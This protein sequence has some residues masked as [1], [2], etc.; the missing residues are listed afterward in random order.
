MYFSTADVPRDA[1]RDQ[2]EVLDAYKKERQKDTL[3]FEF[4]DSQNLREHL[5]NHLPKI[6]EEVR[7]QLEVSN[8]ERK[9]KSEEGTIK[10]SDWD[11]MTER[12]SQSCRSLRA[13]SQWTS[14]TRREV[15]RIAGGNGGMCEA[16]L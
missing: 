5:I 2:L 8:F 4:R 16:L 10:S 1:N 6:V 12:F 7:K 13:D 11:R 14:D 15:W 3:Y 9:A